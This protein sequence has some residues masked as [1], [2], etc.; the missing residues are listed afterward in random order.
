MDRVGVLTLA[1]DETVDREGVERPERERVAIDDQ[2]GRLCFVRH[3]V[4]LAGA[5]DSAVGAIAPV[6]PPG[7]T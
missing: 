7:E 3:P 4:S 1:V 5:S 6:R 2:E